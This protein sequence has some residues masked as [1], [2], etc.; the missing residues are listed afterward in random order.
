MKHLAFSLIFLFA[1]AS[2]AQTESD[3]FAETLATAD[4][5]YRTGD[6]DYFK[7]SIEAAIAHLRNTADSS[8]RELNIESLNALVEAAEGGIAP[9]DYDSLKSKINGL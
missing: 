6:L 7:I 9:E 4:N 2:F 8:Q 5:F 1:T 3:R